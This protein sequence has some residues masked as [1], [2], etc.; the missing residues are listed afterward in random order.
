[1]CFSI[2]LLFFF[3]DSST[4]EIYTYLHTLSLHD[5]LPISAEL[6]ELR[7]LRDD[8]RRLVAELQGRYARETGVAALKVRHNNVLG[9]FVE[10]NAA[11]A[12]RLQTDSRFIHR[13]TL[14]STMSVG[15][16]EQIGRASC[17]ESVC[18]SV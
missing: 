18:K 10:I 3:E 11:N 7:T 6:D 12:P 2:V 5:A 8:S 14:P 16:V 17:R 13:Q 1:M 9:Y 4:T 15:T